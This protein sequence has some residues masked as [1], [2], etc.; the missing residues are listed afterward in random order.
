MKAWI[1]VIFAILIIAVVIGSILLAL[2]AIV[3]FLIKALIVGSAV[4]FIAGLLTIF[5]NRK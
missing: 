5:L 2:Y 1:I 3:G 4:L